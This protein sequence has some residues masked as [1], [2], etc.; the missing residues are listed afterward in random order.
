MELSPSDAMY[1]PLKFINAQKFI[2]QNNFIPVPPIP[3]TT[4]VGSIATNPNFFYQSGENI[5]VHKIP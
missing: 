1:D 5:T 4:K 3:S 2:Q